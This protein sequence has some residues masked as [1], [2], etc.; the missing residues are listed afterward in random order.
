MFDV[1]LVATYALM[2]LYA[3]T[4]GISVAKVFEVVTVLCLFSKRTPLTSKIN[5][6]NFKFCIG[7]CYN[8]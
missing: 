5:Q 7:Q 1:I 8:L 2:R 4:I 3:V 6:N